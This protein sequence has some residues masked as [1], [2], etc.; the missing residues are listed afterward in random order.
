[1]LVLGAFGV[2]GTKAGWSHRTR[3]ARQAGGAAVG[4]PWN[5]PTAG[6]DLGL[7]EIPDDPV[8]FFVK[9]TG[10]VDDKTLGAARPR[11]PRATSSARHLTS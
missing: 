11:L 2:P 7:A 10:R 3:L 1:M 8:E 4:V 5:Q 6:E 9:T